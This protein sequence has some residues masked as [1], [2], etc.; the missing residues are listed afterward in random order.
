MT[1]ARA[2]EM[3]PERPSGGLMVPIVLLMI[4]SALVMMAIGSVVTRLGDEEWF[5]RSERQVA[6][7]L[8]AE[9]RRR[10]Q[11]AKSM[12]NG[13]SATTPR[14]PTAEHDISAHSFVVDAT[15]KLLA[16]AAPGGLGGKDLLASAAAI[17]RGADTEGSQTGY[18]RVAGAIH[19]FAVSRVSGSG[20]AAA[21]YAISTRAMD[22]A[23]LDDVAKQFFLRPLAISEASATDDQ[24]S[25]VLRAPTG[26]PL[27]MLTWEPDLPGRSSLRGLVPPIG[28][29]WAVMIGL[30]WVFA[31]RA[32][33]V[34][35]EL[36]QGRAVLRE[37]EIRREG[38]EALDESEARFRNL[39][40]ETPIAIREEDW[41]VLKRALDAG[42]TSPEDLSRAAHAEP[43]VRVLDVNRAT[44]D[45]HGTR[46]KQEC[47]DRLN[48]LVGE[49]TGAVLLPL[50][51]DLA[52]GPRRTIIEHAERTL[53]GR[54]IIVRKLAQVPFDR[55]DDW[56]RVLVTEEDVTEHRRQQE[57]IEYLAHNDALTGLPN[58]E[59]FGQMLNQAMAMARRRDRRLALLYLDIDDFKSVNETM[60]QAIGDTV[61]QTIADRLRADVRV[62][63]VLGRDASGALSRLA[64]DE[65]TVLLPEVSSPDAAATA[66]ERI[67]ANLAEPMEFPAGRVF[68][69]VSAGISL[70]PE[71]G[72]DADSLLRS[73][74]LALSRTKATRVEGYNFYV[75]AMDAEVLARKALERDLRH[76]VERGELWLS[77]QPL[78]DAHSERIVAVE[79]LVRWNHP[80][81]GL[82]SPTEF[83]PIAE[84]TNM[85]I[86]MGD[87]ILAGA[88]RQATAW[89]EAGLGPVAVSVN[90][91]VAQIQHH[92]IVASVERELAAANLAP[93]YLH[94]E[95]TENVMLSNFAEGL[96]VITNLRRRGIEVLLDDFG[97][98]YSSLS[99]LK[100][101]PVDTVKIDQAF[102]R[103]IP[104][105]TDDIAIVRAIVSMAHAL[106]LKVTAEGV[107]N[108][109][110][111]ELLRQEGCYLL[112]GEH[113]GMPM[114]AEELSRCLPPLS[115]NPVGA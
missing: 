100:N 53:D 18:A 34:T 41:A 9:K 70:F 104:E 24:A 101:F 62:G 30:V 59:L 74:S 29:A 13:F 102:V 77:Y 71:D 3:A 90:V 79:A 33:L 42:M 63:D 51:M 11:I 56:S 10:G 92:D 96:E 47:I 73:A 14:P 75:P 5:D 94:I 86:P 82:V 52:A 12:A 113:Y 103:D 45:V 37:G 36:E 112:Q 19:I 93:E 64:G 28:L 114:P 67:L 2:S 91:S 115:D 39:F 44:L 15:G 20:G 17:F 49:A 80:E 83:I 111:I 97:T 98:G 68:V 60:G 105:S 66:A 23:G 16:G 38:Q 50:A 95:I 31:R 26:R 27:G 40:E 61:L 110:Q 7:A 32:L 69:T 8:G 22:R 87:W 54:E 21:V 99:Y 65:F 57:R 85:I 48:V 58:R 6:A 25:F 43:L 81:R 46:D 88:C 78:V 55:R 84:R 1:N 4:I 106:N 109:A 107:A 89:R 76:A 35:S 72:D 108:Q